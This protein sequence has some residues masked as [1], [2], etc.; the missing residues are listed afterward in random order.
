VRLADV[1]RPLPG[2]A[3]ETGSEPAVPGPRGRRAARDGAWLLLAVYV[4]ASAVGIVLALRSP[5]PSM[6]PD[7]Y[8][9]AHLARGLADGTGSDWHGSDFGLTAALY[10][11]LIAPMW[12][13]FDSS[14]D[15]YAATKVLGTLVLCLQV[16]PVWLLG[17]ELLGDSRLAVVPAALS[18]AGTWML[19][20]S[21]TATEALAFPLT[22]A[23]LCCTVLALRRPVPGRMG[24][25]ALAFALLATWARIQ[26]VVLVPVVLAALALDLLRLPAA[27][28]AA[29][30]R[31]RR[32]F[33]IAAGAIVA[34]GLLLVVADRSA[35]GA[36]DY[37]WDL[38]PG[39]GGILKWTGLQLLE[40][41][42]LGA[43]V[44]VLL[45]AGAAAS[46]RAWRD[47]DA[48][49]LLLVFWLGALATALQSGFYIASLPVIGSGIDRY[50]AYALPLAFV[51]L[52]LLA[53]DPR[54]LGR[55]GW[56]V[57]GALALTLLA[58]PGKVLPAIERGIWT[59][60]H[61]VDQL[62]GIDHGAA[63]TLA[64]LV[65]LA[66]A[67]AAVRRGGA[68]GPVLAAAVVLV[69]LAVQSEAAWK[70]HIDLTRGFRAALGPDL[71][72][73][74]HHSTGPVAF[75]GI[76][77]NPPQFAIVDY[78][79]RNVTRAYAPG[80]GLPGRAMLGGVCAWAI[81]AQ[82]GTLDFQDG[83]AP[84]GRTFLVDDP[85]TQVALAGASSA[86]HSAQLGHLIELPRGT[87][88][89]V[90]A[91]ITVPCPRYRVPGSAAAPC[92]P[93]LSGQLWLDAPGT[94]ELTFRGGTAPHAVAV[95]GKAYDLPAGRATT[96]SL[97]VPKGRSTFAVS[98]DWTDP[99][100]APDLAAARVRTASGLTEVAR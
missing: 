79:N 40:L 78:F 55:A 35:F 56:A 8:L 24:V 5:L 68:R 59:T 42:A 87:K 100:G 9:Y 3:P 98:I 71:A 67:F 80:S 36:Y 92:A 15:A 99:K 91:L 17:R 83:C 82:D 85:T 37:V 7:E 72:W 32:P 57:A 47:D 29:A 96:V 38:R 65:L 13:I 27:R 64:A 73:V 6:Y 93:Q 22:T 44:P 43:F 19:A 20:G 76:T 11:Y 62:T 69:A 2:S 18:V 75:L 86:T 41:V 33:L 34:A 66:L 21:T 46:P 30:A 1:E 97:A 26:L 54:L 28:R 60:T 58:L 50:V 52:V 89:R 74:D 16:V 63:A 10:V 25:L 77:Q 31:A 94:L 70:Q 49:P 84:D 95:A 53:R 12:A 39:V 90:T 23:A 14:V 4:V 51:L 88:P 45:A 61:R 81:G 48:G